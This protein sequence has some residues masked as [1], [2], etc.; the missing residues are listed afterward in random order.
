MK[1]SQAQTKLINQLNEYGFFWK[2]SDR[3]RAGI[4]DVI[5]VVDGRFMSI[6]MKIDY[7]TATPLQ[8]HTLLE[9]VKRGGY[10]AVV[11][12]NNRNKMWWVAGKSFKTPREIA[13]HLVERSR[14][15]KNE[16][17]NETV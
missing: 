1:E 12:Y 8:V 4:P 6:E 10:G 3:F 5:G 13:V 15:G 7:N 9:V 14:T 17:Q 16:I 11:T 2:A